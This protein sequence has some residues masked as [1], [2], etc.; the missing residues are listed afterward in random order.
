[1]KFSRPKI[2]EVV[3]YLLDK[4][5]NSPRFIASV[6]IAPKIRQGQRRTMFSDCPKVHPNRL[7]SGG[8][9]AERVN[10]V[11]IRDKVNPVL[12]EATASRRVMNGDRTALSTAA[13][14][15]QVA[16]CI[17]RHRTSNTDLTSWL[18]ACSIG[19]VSQPASHIQHA[20]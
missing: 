8:V 9:I 16:S 17:T 13:D 14:V 3:R 4:K 6:R 10:I 19:R 11:E 18:V 15:A 2:G 12:G 5:Q 7:T 20:T 1:M